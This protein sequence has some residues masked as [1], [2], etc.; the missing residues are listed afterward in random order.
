M[1]VESDLDSDYC[2]HIGMQFVPMRQDAYKIVDT[3]I[4]FIFSSFKRL[5]YNTYMYYYIIH[6]TV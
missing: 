4:V 6:Q 1:I 5:L 3:E 2:R